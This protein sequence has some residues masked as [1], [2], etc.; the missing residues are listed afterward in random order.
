MDL[1][2]RYPIDMQ[3][4]PADSLLPRLLLGA[5][6][7][8]TFLYAALAACELVGGSPREQ[9]SGLLLLVAVVLPAHLVLV[10]AAW[11]R[12]PGDPHSYV[13]RCA[14][15]VALQVALLPLASG[16]LWLTQE[17]WP[18][19]PDGVVRAGAALEPV[20]AGGVALLLARPAPS[21]T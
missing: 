6:L 18:G 16:L 1:D 3:P 4:T 13:A 10:P 21:R 8:P 7:G 20:L 17:V 15:L 12:P 9:F 11:A 19:V 14:R 5:L 2:L